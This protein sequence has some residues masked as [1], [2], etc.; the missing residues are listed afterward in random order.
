MSPPRGSNIPADL[1]LPALDFLYRLDCV[2]SDDQFHINQPVGGQATRLVFPI[3]GG[4]VQGPK[5]S[6]VIVPNSGAD[7]A[8]T[9]HGGAVMHLNA[10]YTLRTNDGHHVFVRSRGVYLPDANVESP[11]QPPTNVT[12]DQADWFTRLQFEAC[13]GSYEWLNHVFA[14]GV[15]T[16]RDGHILID[17]YKVT[18]FPGRDERSLP[19]KI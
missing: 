17:A 1:R 18:N 3:S 7:W 13:E 9:F 12:Q 2:M 4:T 16:M 5:I 19:S 10:R 6:G 11:E 14:I 15:L 8:T